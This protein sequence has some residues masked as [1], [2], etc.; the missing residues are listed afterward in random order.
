MDHMRPGRLTRGH[1]C[2]STERCWCLGLGVAVEIEKKV[3]SRSILEVRL[4]DFLA[5]YLWQIEWGL[6][7]RG[8][9]LKNNGNFSLKNCVYLPSMY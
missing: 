4:M 2:R 3:H 1:C 9:R 7:R 8:R 5:V 6:K